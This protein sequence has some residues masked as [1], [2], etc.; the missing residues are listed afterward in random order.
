MKR[1]LNLTLAG[2]ALS[3]ASLARGGTYQDGDVLLI[4]RE[5]GFNDVEFDIGD[6]GQFLNHP[7]GYS[8]QVTGWS[9]S[10]VTGVFGAD[11]TGVSVVLA[12]TESYTNASRLAWLSSD[13]SV[14]AVNDVTPSTWQADLWSVIDSIGTRPV[15]YLVPQTPPAGGNWSYSIDPNGTYKLAAYDQIV[16][17]NGVND[18]AIPQLG[19]NAAFQVQGTIPGKLGFWQ[20]QGTN[21][22]P[23]PSA[24]YVGTFSVDATGALTFVAG[25]P[26]AARVPQPTI[27]GITRAA[28]VNTVTFTTSVSGNYSLVY[29]NALGRP[30]TT[31]PVVAGPIAGDGASHSLTHTVSTDNAG[32]YGVLV[33]P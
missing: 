11:L 1:F 33:S 28:G 24:A 26:A 16:S 12:A 31:W 21:A 15:T 5:P 18:A 20:I 3:V 6:V 2:L 10:T 4:F 32:F 22:I 8:N 13:S 14:T 30:V 9:A 7:D 25:P 29:T 19:G 27:L 23:K 17:A